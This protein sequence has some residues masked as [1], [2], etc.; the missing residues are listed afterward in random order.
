MEVRR[1]LRTEAIRRFLATRARPDLARLYTPGSEVQV[2]AAPGRGERVEGVY[3]GRRW[4]GWTDGRVTWKSF[5]IPHA[6][7]R[8]PEYTDTELEWDLDE[9]AEAVGLTGWDWKERRSRWVGFDFDSITTHLEGLTAAELAQLREEVAAIPWI[10]VRTSTSGRGVHLYVGLETPEP[11]ATH[12]EHAALARAVLALAETHCTFPLRAKVDA[13]GGNLWIWHRRQAE[14]GLQLVCEGA[15][16]EAAPP[17]WRAHLDVTSGTRRRVRAFVRGTEFK[18]LASAVRHVPLDAEH[19]A[20]LEWF[21]GAD[22]TSWWDADRHMLVCH[23]FALARAHAEL[24]LRGIF[25]TLATGSG[26]A[27]DQNCFAFPLVGGVWVVRRH[28]RGTAEAASWE[29]DA[30]GWTRCYLNRRPGLD[31]ALVAVGGVR[32]A[33]GGYHFVRGADLLPGLH[34]LGVELRAADWFDEREVTVQQV[35]PKR[36]RQW[37]IA[38]ARRSEDVAPGPEWLMAGRAGERWEV[39][40]KAT[41]RGESVVDTDVDHMRHAVAAES[42]AG[43]FWRGRTGW[44]TEPKGNIISALRARGFSRED[45][46]VLVGLAVQRP[47]RLVNAPFEPEYPGDRTWNI[48]G[49]QL[50]VQPGPG[51]CPTWNDLLAHLGVGLDE[52]VAADEWCRR[53]GLVVGAD[54]LRCWVGA[55]FQEPLEPLPYLAFFGDELAGKSSFHEAL[56][57]LLERGRGYARADTAL[58]SP[59][60]FNAE[61]L[62]AVLCVIE[63]TNLRTSKSAYG[64]LKDW[65]TAPYFQIHAKGRTPYGI[66]NTTHWVQCSNPAS[67]VPVF[68]GDTRVTLVRVE[69]PEVRLPKRELFARLRKEA[70]AF[71][72]QV[73]E[74]ELPPPDERLRIPP[75]ETAEK[76]GQA[77]ASRSA[78]EVFVEE[79]ALEVPGAHVEW[80]VFC[81]RFFRW[82][83]GPERA[84]WGKGRVARELPPR[85]PRGRFGQLGRLHV[86]NVTFDEAARPAGHR[87]TADG[88]RIRLVVNLPAEPPT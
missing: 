32:T 57:L 78:L 64:R 60:G 28:G 74:L 15:R 6:A 7:W 51:E 45:T 33:K 43:W 23:T 58:T 72:R 50:A 69:P 10:T 36:L 71:L 81:D 41:E 86:G 65:V 11:T 21:R 39:C 46:E 79:V 73:S 3:K 4:H 63:E 1:V 31:E 52:A 44:I 56:Q 62:G 67:H 35:Q 5:R 14:D 83:D 47:W 19:R 77:A 59:Q 87:F 82:L 75:L 22:V 40:F 80:R 85:F 27:G 61:L 54:W 49:A 26:G 38:C 84:E 37:V 25:A 34:A 2:N 66:P 24:E 16:L 70:P 88:D 68:P 13:C 17:N 55:L 18:T 42:D 48:Y 20:L 9:H 76:A 12:T 8:E 29:R 53:A 30:G